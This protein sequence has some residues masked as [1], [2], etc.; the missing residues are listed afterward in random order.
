MAGALNAPP[1]PYAAA[2]N[3]DGTD[4]TQFLRAFVCTLWANFDKRAIVQRCILDWAPTRPGTLS[5]V[6]S[7]V[8]P[9][10]SDCRR[11]YRQPAH[12]WYQQY[13]LECKKSC[14]VWRQPDVHEKIM[15]VADPPSPTMKAS[16]YGTQ[17]V[18]VTRAS[19]PLYDSK[20]FT[21]G[22]GSPEPQQSM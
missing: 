9:S 20:T 15:D 14:T 17:A 4:V 6:G 21:R 3:H 7:C 22:S 12:S 2:A 10:S 13:T 11:R 16:R 8:A 1:R 18:Q 19:Q 5:E